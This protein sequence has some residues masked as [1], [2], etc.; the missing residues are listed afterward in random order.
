M[1]KEKAIALLENAIRS[2]KSGDLKD[3]ER[4][5]MAAAQEIKK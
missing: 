5:A 2:L 1:K 4:L 3:A